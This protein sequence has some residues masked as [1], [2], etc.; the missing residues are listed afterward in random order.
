MLVPHGPGL[1]MEVLQDVEPDSGSDMTGDHRLRGLELDASSE[2][3]GLKIL[4]EA[5][6]AW[7]SPLSGYTP[8]GMSAEAGCTAPVGR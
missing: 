1:C 5:L 8:S 3:R 2:K 4:H 6:S 7:Q